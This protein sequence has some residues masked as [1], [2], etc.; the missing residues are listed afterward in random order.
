MV[1]RECVFF[2]NLRQA[3]LLSPYYADRLSSRTVLFTCVPH[4]MLDETKLRKIF[5]DAAKHI[6]IPRET[7][8]L[9][10]LVKDRE[11]TTCRLE[12]AEILLIKK[13]NNAYIKALKNGHPDIATETWSQDSQP[14]GLQMSIISTSPIVSPESP[15]SPTEKDP[16]SPPM[17][18]ATL[19]SPTSPRDF[20]RS[21]GVP[22]FKTSFGFDGPD[23]EVNG[24]VAALWIPYSQRPVHRPL[25][26]YGRRIDTIKW[27][28]NQLKQ[29]APKIS[30]LRRKFKI[31]QEIP[32]PAVFIEF[33]SQVSAQSAYQTLA[34]HRAN[35]MVPEIVGVTPQE[36][37]WDSL[38]MRWWERIVRRFAIQAFIAV[39]VVF[40]SI[41]CVLVGI[42][43]QV[44]F[45]TEMVP[46]LSWIEKLPAVILGLIS[47][48]LPAV[49]LS[50]V[51]SAVPFIM[52]GMVLPTH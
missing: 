36:I 5:G 15:Q 7:E 46:F 31:R 9:D 10:D 38:C 25:A 39:L 50:L 22:G 42:I 48:L 29:M 12:K 45:L 34:H 37:V 52:R 51:M 47:G 20:S 3:Y 41:P 23:P 32:I 8:E 24:S 40:W 26:N 33:D 14:K 21:D 13:V 43:S 16:T 1:S 2:I 11:A 28:R 30:K 18:P 27:T 4:Q 35:H 44:K 6:W 19:V 49:A 17:S